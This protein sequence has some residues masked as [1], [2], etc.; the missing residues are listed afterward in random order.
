M[1]RS[2]S[3]GLVVMGAAAFTASFA[4]G[5]AFLAWQNPAQSLACTSRPDGTQAC[6]TT[7]TPAGIARY[8][9][10]SLF[11]G[12]SAATTPAV[13]ATGAATPAPARALQDGT[14]RRGFGASARTAFRG[15]AGG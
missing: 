10:V 13:R 4:G 9:H 3:L 2:A 14:T 11:P 7:R 15:S 5:S 6:S 1:K 12:N 8:V